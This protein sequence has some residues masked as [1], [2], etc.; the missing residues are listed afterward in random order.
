[1]AAMNE[2]W[3]ITYQL[4]RSELVRKWWRWSMLRASMLVAMAAALTVAV[5]SLT[6]GGGVPISAFLLAIAIALPFGT[7]KAV[8]NAVDANPMLTDQKTVEFS[9][10]RI[11]ATGTDW[12]IETPWSLFGRCS[13]DAE[14]FYLQQTRSTPPSLF[15]K[16]AFTAEQIVSFREYAKGLRA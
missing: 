12:K 14:F 4:A 9:P 15:P 5:A 7:R 2:T 8:A 6:F 10:S 3:S 11:V 1:M 13:E 16:R